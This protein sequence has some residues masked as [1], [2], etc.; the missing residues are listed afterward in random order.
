M[1]RDDQQ[2]L[3]DTRDRNE[4]F[5]KRHGFQPQ[6]V[7]RKPTLRPARPQLLALSLCELLNS[8][9]HAEHVFRQRKMAAFFENR[10]QL[11][12]LRTGM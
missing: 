10:D 11:V 12:E 9:P 7:S 1:L 2:G 5:L 8:L 6:T 4:S 3:R